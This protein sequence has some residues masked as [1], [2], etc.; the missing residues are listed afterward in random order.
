MIGAL[1]FKLASVLLH[2]GVN[3]TRPSVAEC[4]KGWWL[5]TGVRTTGEFECYLTDRD[6][7]W[8]A[9]DASPLGV[10]GGRI[11][12]RPGFAPLVIDHRRVA[13]RRARS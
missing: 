13:C 2:I 4:P 1:L 6:D 9:I 10:I 3:I 7:E 12:C 5:A 11:Y 8:P